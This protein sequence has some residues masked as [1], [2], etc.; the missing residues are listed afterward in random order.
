MSEFGIKEQVDTNEEFEKLK[1]KSAKQQR[2]IDKLRVKSREKT[3]RIKEL[4]EQVEKLKATED[5]E[6]TEEINYPDIDYKHLFKCGAFNATR[7]AMD[8][9]YKE[10]WKALSSGQIKTYKEWIDQEL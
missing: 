8:E 4:E 5:T 1:K 9:E 6:E 2:D 7:G 10:C 3:E